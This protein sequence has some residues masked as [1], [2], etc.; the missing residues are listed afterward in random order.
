[1]LSLQMT[2]RVGKPQRRTGAD[3]END[4]FLD[5][6]GRRPGEGGFLR[7]GKGVGGPGD[8][9]ALPKKYVVEWP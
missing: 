9:G 8:G 3:L 5:G 1:M 2:R 4:S 6:G 7:W